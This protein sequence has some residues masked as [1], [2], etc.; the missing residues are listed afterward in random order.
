MNFSI[1]PEQLTT[2]LS[3][4]QLE[5]LGLPLTALGNSHPRSDAVS[6]QKV[7]RRLTSIGANTATSCSLTGAIP[8]CHRWPVGL[9]PLGYSVILIGLE[10]E[11][12]RQLLWAG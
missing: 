9:R 4:W 7:S 3:L 10:S 1:W 6:K 8:R 5:L 2:S 11:A 12:R